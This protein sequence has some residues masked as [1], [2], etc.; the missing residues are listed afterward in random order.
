MSCLGHQ[1]QV[2]QPRPLGPNLTIWHLFLVA[3]T[4]C[5]KY[6][7]CLASKL[8]VKVW[9][10]GLHGRNWRKKP[11]SQVDNL[12]LK[13][14]CNPPTPESPNESIRWQ[15]GDLHKSYT[16]PFHIFTSFPKSSYGEV[17]NSPFRVDPLSRCMPGCS[18]CHHLNRWLPCDVGNLLEPPGHGT[19]HRL[20]A[21]EFRLKC[22][23]GNFRMEKQ[24]KEM[25]TPTSPATSLLPIYIYISYQHFSDDPISMK[26]WSCSFF[27]SAAC[28]SPWCRPSKIWGTASEPWKHRSR[29]WKVQ[30]V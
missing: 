18:R 13:Q 11:S 29:F 27:P 3:K 20:C 8:G 2:N 21:Y 1:Y 4:P 25:P 30:Q 22:Q 10:M 5:V 6:P 28:T 14:V 15:R 24:N 26:D 16:W 9:F 19:L 17:T 12:N 23:F 7:K